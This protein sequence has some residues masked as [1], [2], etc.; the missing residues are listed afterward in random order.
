MVGLFELAVGP[1][2][3]VGLMMESAVGKGSAQAFVKEEE[4]QGDLD[5]FCREAVGVARS[6]ALQQ[7]MTFEL[8][9]IIA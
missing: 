8:A 5:T 4:Q 7:S 3:G 6:V 1:I 9:Q 2:F